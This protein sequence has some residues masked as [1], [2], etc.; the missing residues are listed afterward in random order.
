M[1]I[2]PLLLLQDIVKSEMGYMG[3]HDSE[4]YGL[5]WKVRFVFQLLITEF[6][7]RFRYVVHTTY[8]GCFW[9]WRGV[10]D[11]F[12]FRGDGPGL[13]WFTFL[14]SLIVDD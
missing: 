12:R 7:P 9:I 11:A 5:T 8:R 2:P 3:F 14:P 4:S 10:S 6:V 1:R 13:V